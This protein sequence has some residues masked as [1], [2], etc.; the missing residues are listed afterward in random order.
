MI[1]DSYHGVLFLCARNLSPDVTV[2]RERL[3]DS[4]IERIQRIHRIQHT[5]GKWNRNERR[6]SE[7][8]N[9]Y[10]RFKG[11]GF[12]VLC[13]GRVI[14][15]L[16]PNGIA[17]DLRGLW[18]RSFGPADTSKRHRLLKA[19]KSIHMTFL[20]ISVMTIGRVLRL[21]IDH[22]TLDPLARLLAIDLPQP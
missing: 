16:P 15:F 1:N 3:D 4:G 12:A 7:L 10:G 13:Y 14:D 22:T 6:T 19:R 18:S 11:R 21:L 17:C 5:S 2:Q 20:H 8:L 9:R